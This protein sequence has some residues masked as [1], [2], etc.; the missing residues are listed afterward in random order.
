MFADEDVESIIIERA[1]EEC[2]VLVD[3]IVA[4]G[5]EAFFLKLGSQARLIGLVRFC[6][7]FQP[8]ARPIY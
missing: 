1:R 5:G 7:R 4:V 2:A 6:R 3:K 8:M